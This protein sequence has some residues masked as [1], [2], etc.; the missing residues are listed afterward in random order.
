[1]KLKSIK[2]IRACLRHV[3]DNGQN[4]TLAELILT[5]EELQ[6]IEEIEPFFQGYTEKWSSDKKTTKHMVQIDILNLQQYCKNEIAKGHRGSGNLQ[7]LLKNFELQLETRLPESGVNLKQ[8]NIGNFFHPVRKGW[9]VHY[10]TENIY[11]LNEIIQSF[12]DTHPT[13]QA[14][15][16]GLE[17]AREGDLNDS[18]DSGNDELLIDAYQQFEFAKSDK[19]KV[20]K[21]KCPP[22]EIEIHN[23]IEMA[24]PKLTV[25]VLQWW[26]EHTK[27]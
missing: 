1:M 6:M 22:M 5:P 4:L 24:K 25:N 15:F 2:N 27:E 19:S 8:Y 14:Y 11:K 13:T 23:Y 10:I 16:E 17:G 21:L 20:S 12:I 9:S 7:E 26:K 18:D 3:L